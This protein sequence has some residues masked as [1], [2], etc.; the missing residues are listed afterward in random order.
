MWRSALGNLGTTIPL[1]ITVFLLKPVP[2]YRYRYLSTHNFHLQ[3]YEPRGKK[4]EIGGNKKERKG[5][6][7]KEERRKEKGK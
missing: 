2:L 1:Q 7:R 4:I 6:Q 3:Q 5:R